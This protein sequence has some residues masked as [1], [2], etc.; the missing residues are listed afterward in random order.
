MLRNK[1]NLIAFILLLSTV[2]LAQKSDI[3]L[4]NDKATYEAQYEQKR[5]VKYLFAH[6]KN[7]LVKYNPLS[8]AL[9]GMLYFYQKVLSQQLG[10]NCPYEQSCSA[11]GKNSIQHWG[12]LKGI[13]LTADRLM[14]CTKLASADIRITDINVLGK[15]KDSPLRYTFKKDTLHV[16]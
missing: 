8:L 5:T 3:S 11:F 9:G 7:I 6:K 12:L 14:R 16:H 15:I 4:L 2:C 13:P 1:I 10:A